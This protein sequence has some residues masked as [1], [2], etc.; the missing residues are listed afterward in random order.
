MKFWEDLE[1]GDE[2][3]EADF[4]DDWHDEEDTEEVDLSRYREGLQR[5]VANTN[6]S[7]VER[8][9]LDELLEWMFDGECAAIDGCYPVEPDGHC[10][11]G[12]PSWFLHLNLI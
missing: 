8:P 5:L 4:M 3:V 10:S 2:P 1:D 6:G 11:H 9:T 7:I 12:K